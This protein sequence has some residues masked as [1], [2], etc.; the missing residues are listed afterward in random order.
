MAKFYGEI[1]F[2]ESVEVEPG[3]WEDVIIERPY[4]G[5]VVRDTLEVR[6]GDKVL[7]DL[8]TGN[9]FSIM[10]DGYAEDNF[11][12]MRYVKWSGARWSVRQV[13]VKRPRLLIRI[14]GVYSG[15]TPGTASGSEGDSGDG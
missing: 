7:N 4:F 14:G 10:A 9:S 2:G 3:V 8:R 6:Q 15:P 11:F 1:G 13:E 12:A 5:D